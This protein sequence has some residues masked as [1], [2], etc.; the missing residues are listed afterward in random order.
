[1]D[2]PAR[3]YAPTPSTPFSWVVLAI[4][5]GLAVLR[6]AIATRLDGFTIDEPYHVVAGVSDV[7]TADFR[8]DPEHPPLMKLWAGV[9]LSAAGFRL[10]AFR[11]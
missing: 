2:S 6:S 10:P 8:L 11:P 4:L 5:I 7:R 1:M 3:P 9:A